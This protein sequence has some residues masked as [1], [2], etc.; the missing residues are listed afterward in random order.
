MVDSHYYMPIDLLTMQPE[1][2]SY[3]LRQHAAH[4]PVGRHRCGGMKSGLGV[5]PTV[6]PLPAGILGSRPY[7]IVLQCHTTRNANV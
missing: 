2:T 1:V 7:D 4:T 6:C 3:T 5:C